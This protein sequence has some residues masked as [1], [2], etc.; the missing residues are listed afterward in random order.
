[1]MDNVPDDLDVDRVVGMTRPIGK[2]GHL[3]P[4][5]VDRLVL[6]LIREFACCLTISR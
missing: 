5:Y 4:V 1:M 6:Q 2:V 3:T